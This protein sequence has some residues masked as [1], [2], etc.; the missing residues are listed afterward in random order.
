MTEQHPRSAP[1]GARNTAS[2]TALV[3]AG[4]TG[5]HIFPGLAVAQALQAQG[6]RVHWLGAPGSMESRL[7]PQYGIP[8]ELI[9]FTGVRGKGLGALVRLPLRLLRALAQSVQVLRR[10]RPDVVLAWA[11]TSPSRPGS[12][13][14]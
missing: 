7:V 13:P 14:W 10:V 6:W 12:W 4:G 11:A 1:Q 9:E 3:M 2:K 5:G 8:L